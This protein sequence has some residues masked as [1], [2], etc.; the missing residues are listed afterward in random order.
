MYEMQ[1]NENRMSVSDIREQVNYVQ[2]IMQSVM[3]DKEHYG[4][5]PGCGDKPTLLKPG[6][7]KLLMTF[8]MSPEIVGED[9]PVDMPDGHREYRIKVKLYSRDGLF[10]GD[11]VG[12]C[13]TMESKY[14]YRVGPVTFTGKP[15]PKDYWTLRKENFIKAQELIGGKGYAV[16]KE[17][18]QYQIVIQGERVGHDNPADFFNTVLKMAK[19]RAMVDAVLTVTA[20]SDIFTQDIDEFSGVMKSSENPTN[21]PPLKSPEKKSQS[22]HHTDLADLLGQNLKGDQAAM[23][24]KLIH[25]TTWTDKDGK[26]HLGKDSFYDISEKMAQVAYGK[27]KQELAATQQDKDKDVDQSEW[28]LYIEELGY[29]KF[30]SIAKGYGDLSKLT[31]DLRMD[32]VKKLS[33]EIDKQQTN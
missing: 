27:F 23:K 26:E 33:E 14:R 24:Q 10:L 12:S 8:R 4:T 22:K 11:G 29:G 25:L 30:E 7:E 20:A 3:Q 16:K 5:I 13:S 21:K 31:E 1:V 9:N 19:K 15:V 28:D 18:G 32:L 6:A 17:N 2:E